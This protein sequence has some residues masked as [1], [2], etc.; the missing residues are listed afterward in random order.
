MRNWIQK[1]REKVSSKTFFHLHLVSD[2]T[3]ET[4]ITLGRAAAAQYPKWRAVEHTSP[5]VRTSEEL[6]KALDQIEGAPGIVLYTIIDRE[7]EKKL[8]NKCLSLGVP[9]LNVLAP[10]MKLFD[11]YLGETISGRTGA[12]HVLDEEYFDRLDAIKFAMAHDDGNLPDDIE[13]ADI[14]LIGI[15]RTSKTPTSIYLAQRGVKTFNI[16]LVP[17]V[18]LPKEVLSVKHPMVVALVASA[19]RILQVRENRLLAFDRDLAGDTYVDRASIQEEL[20]W[21]RRLCKENNWP[22]IDVS[23][24]SIE[25]TS[26][27]IL[28]LRQ[29]HSSETFS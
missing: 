1:A 8:Q 10:T 11:S 3:G 23:K 5:M 27:A 13:E 22:M 15:S 14:I 6:D 19:E 12:Q 2:S 26:A 24:R 28:A 16:P 4:L 21:T 17:G 18:D 7:L 29:E 25:E 9:A 20:T